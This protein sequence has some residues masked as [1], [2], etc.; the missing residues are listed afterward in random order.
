MFNIKPNPFK[1]VVKE[2]TKSPAIRYLEQIIEK[3]ILSHAS[4]I[5][6][7][8]FEN[9]TRI[10]FRIDGILYSKD[11]IDKN[12]YN[13]VV[14][15]VKVISNLNIAENRRPQD[16]K[17]NPLYLKAEYDLRVSILP[18]VYG[19]K[20][21]IRILYKEGFDIGLSNIGFS[22]EDSLKIKKALKSDMGMILLTGPTG[23]GKTT[24]MYSMINYLNEEGKNIVT[25]EDP[26]EYTIKGINQ[27]NV[28]YKAGVDFAC[29]LRSIL[30]QDPDVI[31]IGE[32]RDEET[33]QIAVRAA[34]TG[35]LVLS[36][37][38]ANNCLGTLN[39]LTDM[40]VPMYMVLDAVTAVL[41]QRLI[42]KV[43]EH[44]KEEYT[45][46]SHAINKFNNAIKKAYKGKGCS[47]CHNTGYLGRV[48]AYELLILS[49]DFKKSIKDK[50]S[51]F[52][53]E[54]LKSNCMK[55]VASGITSIDELNKISI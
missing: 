28:N 41:S 31:M 21:V 54:T 25:I 29:G 9:L 32:I 43:C 7:E 47:L 10:R 27:V 17:I 37:V 6:F 45:L 46:P 3:G 38:H 8:P 20:V 26:V 35:H 2:G 44:C 51:N 13:S 19:E 23:S 55:M 24:T 4:D 15:R 16:G 18:I 5:H 34:I 40:G 49:D 33:A 42:R 1:K 11:V 50:K 12:L 30:R 52:P 36:T 22:S 39:R 53:Y 48:I 14:L